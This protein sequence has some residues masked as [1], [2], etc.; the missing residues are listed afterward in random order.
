MTAPVLEM[1]FFAISQIGPD[2]DLVSEV[3]ALNDSGITVPWVW[4]LYSVVKESAMHAVPTLTFGVYNEVGTLKYI[5]GRENLVPA[6]GR[7][8]TWS[9]GYLAGMYDTGIP[10][11]AEV[12]VEM[13][14]EVLDEFLRTR[15]RPTCIEWKAAE[16][17]ERSGWSG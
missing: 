8:D 3:R 9:T 4:S 1:P 5:D 7:N 17:F 16:R 12:P 15:E 13:V 14:Y 10:P 11:Y 6:A 2:V